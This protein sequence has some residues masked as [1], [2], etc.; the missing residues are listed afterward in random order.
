MLYA[1]NTIDVFSNF[2][3]HAFGT[4]F[5]IKHQ[6]FN[7]SFHNHN[8]HNSKSNSN[9][10]YNSIKTNINSDLS[11]KTQECFIKTPFKSC[12]QIHISTQLKVIKTSQNT[13][14]IYCRF[15]MKTTY[16]FISIKYLKHSIILGE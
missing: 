7:G 3:D 10:Q 14:S 6:Y 9:I 2:H 15:D 1:Q 16:Y 8:L 4:Q 13:Y 5:L 12:Y 11:F